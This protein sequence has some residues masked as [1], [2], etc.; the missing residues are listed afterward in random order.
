MH[1]SQ[2]MLEEEHYRFLADEARRTGQSISAVLREWI[3]QRMRTQRRAPLEQDPLWDMVGI[4]HGG[5]D[6]ISETHD[7]YLATVR[8]KRK[9]RRSRQSR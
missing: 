1:R 6:R 7:H 5:R 4:A 8:L 9:A 2:V 3:T